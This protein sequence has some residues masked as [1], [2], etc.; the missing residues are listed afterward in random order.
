M[1]APRPYGLASGQ[2]STAA[3]RMKE[4]ACVVIVLRHMAFDSFIY[5]QG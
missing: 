3:S 1:H 5:R 2:L 4:V